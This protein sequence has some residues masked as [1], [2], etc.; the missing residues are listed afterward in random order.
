MPE[1][2]FVCRESCTFWFHAG[3]TRV[4]GRDAFLAFRLVSRLGDI[5]IA[6]AADC[7]ECAGFAFAAGAAYADAAAIGRQ[8]WGTGTAARCQPAFKRW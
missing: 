7:A 8:C 6:A 1:S 2:R 4:F 5:G 3:G